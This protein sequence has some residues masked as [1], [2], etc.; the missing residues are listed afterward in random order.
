MNKV[1]NEDYYQNKWVKHSEGVYTINLLGICYII[2]KQKSDK[3]FPIITCYRQPEDC[4]DPENNLWGFVSPY[5]FCRGPQRPYEGYYFESL[6]EA[7]RAMVKDFKENLSKL[8]YREF[9]RKQLS[10]RSFL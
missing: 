9:Y 6:E 5:G 2:Q 3:P 7:K 8:I 1:D 10:L 4:L